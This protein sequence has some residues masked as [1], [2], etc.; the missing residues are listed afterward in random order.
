MLLSKNHTI[1]DCCGVIKD[2]FEINYKY[3]KYMN[4]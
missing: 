4:S 2:D 3:F 1:W